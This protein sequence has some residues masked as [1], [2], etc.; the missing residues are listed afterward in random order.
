MDIAELLKT[1]PDSFLQI[2]NY[3]IF[4]KQ[5]CFHLKRKE[6]RRTI[7]IQSSM[8][9]DTVVKVLKDDIRLNEV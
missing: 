7:Q 8:N 4:Y 9:L 1:N 6:G 3:Q 2:G 5:L